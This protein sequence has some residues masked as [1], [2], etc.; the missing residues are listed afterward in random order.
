MSNM[1][2]VTPLCLLS[3]ASIFFLFYPKKV[4]NHQGLK[5]ALKGKFSGGTLFMAV[6]VQSGFKGINPKP[7][8]RLKGRSY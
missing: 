5:P 6:V 1:G 2:G 8:S 3:A 4:Q 7:T